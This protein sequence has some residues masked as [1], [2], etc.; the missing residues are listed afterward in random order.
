MEWQQ[1]VELAE[2][3]LDRIDDLPEQAEDF[4]ISVEEKTRDL[5]AW[6]KKHRECTPKIAEALENMSRGVDRWIP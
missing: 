3:I 6:V 1:A 4:G 2:S 5:L